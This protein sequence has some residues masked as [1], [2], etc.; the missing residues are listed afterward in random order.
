MAPS[1]PLRVWQG[2]EARKKLG[3]ANRLSTLATSTW[4][5]R[6]L[7]LSWKSAPSVISL[8]QQSWGKR[9]WIAQTL[10]TVR[11]SL[12]S[13]ASTRSSAR[14]IKQMLDKFFKHGHSILK[15]YINFRL[16]A[17]FSGVG[18]LASAHP[19]STTNGRTAMKKTLLEKWRMWNSSS[20]QNVSNY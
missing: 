19:V 18:S 20:V 13:P 10:Q 8:Q 5:R 2:V 11:Q 3:P 14:W 4:V 6:E 1:A 16:M 15:K 17:L 7:E 9:S 12:A